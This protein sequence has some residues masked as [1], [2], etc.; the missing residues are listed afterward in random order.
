MAKLSLLN[1][2]AQ[3]A[4]YWLADPTLAQFV[5]ELR[6]L[7]LVEAAALFAA[8]PSLLLR[9]SQLTLLG[10]SMGEAEDTMWTLARLG[11]IEP[12]ECAD[13]AEFA[14]TA[15][16]LAQSLLAHFGAALR[17]SDFRRTITYHILNREQ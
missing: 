11:V 9:P 7:S 1:S 16:P 12:L 3:P 17:S 15:A 5:S 6:R 2:A 4:A 13:D 14:V 10:Y 8:N